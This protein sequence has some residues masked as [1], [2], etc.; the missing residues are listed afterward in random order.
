MCKK[1]KTIS[2]CFTTEMIFRGIYPK[3]KK[4]KRKK[5]HVWK[6][7]FLGNLEYQTFFWRDDET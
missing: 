5:F 4:R 7:V 3:S 6:D 2:W 1:N